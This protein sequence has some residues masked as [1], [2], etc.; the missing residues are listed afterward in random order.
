MEKGNAIVWPEEKRFPL[1][2]VQEM[3]DA[4][5]QTIAQGTD[6]VTLMGRAAHGAFRVIRGLQGEGWDPVLSGIRGFAG[7]TRL[8]AREPLGKDP[9]ILVAA[10]GGNNGGD[11]WALACELIRAGHRVRV[12]SFSEKTTPASR[13]YREEAMRLGVPAQAWED[14][15]KL[16]C[17]DLAVDCLL[18]TGFRGEPAGSILEGI[19]AI[20]RSGIPVLAMDINSGMN[21]DTG[22]AFIRDGEPLCTDSWVTMTIG[23]VKKGLLEAE[24][25]KHIG[26]LMCCDIGIRVP[27]RE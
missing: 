17:A 4:D 23:L 9:R 22:T 1:Y 21:G 6:A 10:G 24:A 14:G 11:G 2:S 26:Y 7:N 5:S 20:R 27:D 25:R 16:P 3:R 18:G 15:G 13:Y 8:C 12:V 19:T